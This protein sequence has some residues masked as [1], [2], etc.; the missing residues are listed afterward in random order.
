MKKRMPKF[1]LNDSVYYVGLGK[2]IP[3]TVIGISQ[4]VEDAINRHTGKKTFDYHA[5]YRIHGYFPRTTLGHNDLTVL[6]YV[7][8]SQ[9]FSDAK[10]AEEY[11]N[12]QNE[13]YFIGISNMAY[14]H[15]KKLSEMKC[16]DELQKEFIKEAKKFCKKLRDYNKQRYGMRTPLSRKCDEDVFL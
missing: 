2:I 10:D 16:G 5:V 4:Y 1:H 3:A 12:E 6:S 13:K 9:L 8:E 14:I 7:K 15:M 11:L